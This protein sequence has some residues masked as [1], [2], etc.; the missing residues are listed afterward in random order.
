MNI[1]ITKQRKSDNWHDLYPDEAI[2]RLKKLGNVRF[3]ETSKPFTPSELIE[4][5]GDVDI[6]LTEWQCPAFTDM[7]VAHAGR[8]KLIAH[9]GGSV[10]NTASESVYAKGIKVCSANA[11]MAKFVA[12]GVLAY[13]LAGLRLIPQHDRL[14]RNKVLWEK[15]TNE[16]R[17]LYGEKIGFVGLGAVGVFLLELLKPFD[18]NIMLYDPYIN[19]HLLQSYPNVNLGSLEDTLSWGNIISVHAALT[20]ETFHLINEHNLGLIK[21]HALLI[22]TARGKI[23]E[24][25]ALIGHLAKG[26]IRAVLDVYEREPL[27]TDSSLRTLDN[28]LVMPHMAASP[29]REQMTYAMIEEIERFINGVA[30]QHEMPLERYK[31]MTRHV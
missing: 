26:R 6:C 20:P 5:I 24:E 15:R 23:V 1:L 14:M 21:D 25:Q 18:V 13:M 2:E 27:D 3:N 9:A 4:N 12:E 17:S 16:S 22:N 8:L 10:A 30:L 31:L 29:S 11:I 7:V 19:K 28:V